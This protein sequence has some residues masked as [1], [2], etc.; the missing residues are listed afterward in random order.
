MEFGYRD[1]KSEPGS[2]GRS[3]VCRREQ[4]AAFVKTELVW[5]QFGDS[6]SRHRDTQ[7]RTGRPALQPQPDA[8]FVVNYS[9]F[10]LLMSVIK[11]A[12]FR[13]MAIPSQ[14]LD[15]QYSGTSVSERNP[16]RK[17]V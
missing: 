13:S 3:G 12:L 11:N 10:S 15:R 7:R 9:T 14:E 6:S 2:R 5:K 4:S 1:V 17:A 16:F 8:E